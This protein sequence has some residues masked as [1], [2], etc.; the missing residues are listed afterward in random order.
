MA[1]TKYILLAA[2]LLAAMTTTYATIMCYSGAIVSGVAA[3]AEVSNCVECGSVTTT[4][5]SITTVTQTCYLS[6]TCSSGCC[7]TAL[8]NASTNITPGG[9]LVGLLAAALYMLL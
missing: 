7:Y 5:F 1:T 2:C 8:C 3:N 6:A 4:V 9:A